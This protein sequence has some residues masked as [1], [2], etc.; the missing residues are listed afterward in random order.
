MKKFNLFKV[1]GVVILAYVVMSWLLPFGMYVFG[2]KNIPANE[3]GII[4]IFSVFVEA[5]SG[6]GS[7]F[8][9]I[10]AVGGFYAILDATGVYKKALNLIVKKLKGKEKLFL[11]L[12]VVFLA[13]ISSICGLEL[14][15]FVIFPFVISIILLLG[16]DNLTALSA[17]VGSTIIGIYG[18]TFSSTTY[19]ITNQIVQTTLLDNILAK[20]ILFV[21]GLGVLIFFVL[22]HIKKNNIKLEQPKEVEKIVSEKTKRVWP[23]YVILGLVFLIFVLGTTSWA[24]IFGFNWFETAHKA[25]TSLTINK[26]DIFNKLFGGIEALGTWNTPYRMQYYSILILLASVIIS[27]IYRV[28]AKDAVDSFFKGVK[29]YLV[30][31][32]LVVICCSVFIMVYYYPILTTVTDWILSLSKDFNVATASIFTL[33]SS[34]LYVDFYYYAYYGLSSLLSVTT[35]TTLFPLISVLF[36][37]LYGLVMLI[38]PTSMILMATLAITEVNYKEWFK[39][40]WKLFLS[41]LIVSLIVFIIMLLV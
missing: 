3:V 20:V 28:K 13:I 27:I 2:A 19:G 29:E 6:F 25:W 18:S 35:D 23:L 9:F 34:S 16:Y 32:T 12:T 38:A 24:G 33:L 17:T 21:L 26:F 22:H 10:L 15:L 40:I 4:S 30:P 31:A 36:T 41:L 5:F 37:N 39:Y 7:S 14:G 11:I 8:I 1:L